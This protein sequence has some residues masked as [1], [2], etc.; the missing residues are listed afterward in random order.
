MSEDSQ[1]KEVIQFFSTYT[2]EK[3]WWNKGALVTIPFIF[4]FLLCAFLVVSPVSFGTTVV[5]IGIRVFAL[6]LLLRLLQRYI[7]T[8]HTISVFSDRIEFGI[9]GAMIEY[10]WS[11]IEAVRVRSMRTNGF[12][13]IRFKL[14]VKETRRRPHKLYV[15][16][17]PGDSESWGKLERLQ[18]IFEHRILR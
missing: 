15:W 10:P 1:N 18:E 16:C 14:H 6:A 8:V 12:S 4:L 7:R 17:L 2:C 13:T 5:N 9:S 11:E 3:K